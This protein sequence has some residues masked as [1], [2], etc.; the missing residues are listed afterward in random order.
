MSLVYCIDDV[1]ILTP[2]DPSSRGPLPLLIYS[3]GT[4][5]QVKYHIWY[6]TMSCSARLDLVGRA[7]S[8]GAAHVLGVI[9]PQLVP[10]PD[11]R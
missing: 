9:P 8:D 5:L 7:T 2:L 11:S 4:R 3:E 6:Y 1:Y 10:E